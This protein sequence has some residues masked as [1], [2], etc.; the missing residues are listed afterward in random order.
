MCGIAGF[1]GGGTR[2][3]LEAMTGTLVH[4]G[5]DEAGFH[6]DGEV[7]LGIR[8]LS[9]VDVEGGHQPLSSEDGQVVVVFNGEIYNHAELREGLLQRGHRLATASDGEVLVHLYEEEGESL[10]DRLNGMFGLALWDARRRRLLLARD[11]IGIKPLYY[12]TDGRQL[13]FGSELRALLRHPGVPRDL[14][15]DA[16]D[17][18]LTFEYVPAPR[19]IFAGIRKLPP[20][21]FLTWDAGGLEVRRYWSVEY[22]PERGVPAR[23]WEERLIAALR[24][25][26]RRR[27]MADVPLGA[28]LSGGIDSSTI[29]AL[30]AQEAT[31]AVKTFSIGFLEG[32]FDESEPAR[33]VATLLG[34]RHHEQILS[35]DRCLE[36]VP[37]L[38]EVLD[39]PLGDASIV[40]TWLLCQSARREVTVA[41]SG[42]GGD[43]LLAGYPTYAAAH[44]AEALRR[45]PRPL[46]R[47]GQAAA[48]RLPVSTRNW[49]LDFRIKRFLGRAEDPPEQRN[50]LWVGSFSPE[51]KAD[52]YGPA[53]QGR[54][55]TFEPLA[56]LLRPGLDLTNRLLFADLHLYLA[57][58]LLTKVDRASMAVSLEARVPFLDHQVVELMARVPPELKLRGMTTKH[59]LKQA[60]RH[61]LPADIRLRPKKGFGIPVADWL[62]GPLRPW[63]EDLVRPE[64]VARDGLFRP[65]G[66]RRLVDEHMAG[67]ADHRK[68]LWTLAQFLQWRRAWG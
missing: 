61:L 22:R 40:P 42:E 54:T 24:T 57:D 14:D 33:R 29:V 58:D 12:W 45:I 31:G 28:F 3:V 16:L 15:L 53:M 48:G 50:V 32:S 38:P 64:E 59:L 62:K 35:A 4:R 56:P 20:A 55:A 10:L 47:A 26:V 68:L 23:E 18:Y 19:S 41:L 39:E 46:L 25:S 5:P 6:L 60:T 17:Q 63:L 11:R 43:E 9:I 66:V 49:S 30:M 36:L 65:E 27:L 44:L 52:L 2:E 67:R 51:E 34:T 1:A 21:H 37:R 8:R 13:A 7:G